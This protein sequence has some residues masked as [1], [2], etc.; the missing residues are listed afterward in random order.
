M[1]EE[2]KT[3]KKRAE[4]KEEDQ[5][6]KG[7]KTISE[8]TSK[9][10]ETSAKATKAKTV[11]KAAAPPKKSTAAR[12]KK[13]T[14][15]EAEAPRITARKKAVSK[16][17]QAAGIPKRG[18]PTSAHEAIV[19]PRLFRI[20]KHKKHGL[21]EFRRENAHRW[22]RLS[23]SWRNVRGN[24]SYTRQKRKG[25]IAMVNAGYRTP[26]AARH[27]HPSMHLEV[28][29]YNAGQLEGLDP[30]VYAV[31]IGGTVG[32]RKR[33]DILKKAETM[34]LRVLNPGAPESAREEEL[35]SELDTEA[36]EK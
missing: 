34:N 21:P 32:M 3:G 28:P 6:K 8:K 33:R 35:F 14:E 29:V 30:E 27:I 11:K 13:P 5:K 25:R 26:K 20:A 23:D 17:A 10:R 22:I 12:R 4:K 7:K 16:G 2:R 19:E 24:D 9:A 31:R 15:I 36:D 18:V 1:S